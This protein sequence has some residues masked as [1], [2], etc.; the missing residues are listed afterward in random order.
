MVV[1]SCSPARVAQVESGS[2]CTTVG[3]LY[4]HL[5]VPYTGYLPGETVHARISLKNTTRRK[6]QVGAAALTRFGVSPCLPCRLV[7][8]SAM[9]AGSVSGGETSS[10]Q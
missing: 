10:R 1:H 3:H 4:G 2:C 9:S 8:G 5:W 7:G 6:Q